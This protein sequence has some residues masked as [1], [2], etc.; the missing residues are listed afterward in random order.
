MD[1]EVHTVNSF[2]QNKILKLAEGFDPIA[3]TRGGDIEAFK[4]R[5]R[6]IWGVIWHPERMDAAVLPKD[7]KILFG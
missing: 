2:H 7:L 6:N 3:T 1:D 4:H 5:K